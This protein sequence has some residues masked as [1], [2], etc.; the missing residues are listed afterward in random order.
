MRKIK[1]AMIVMWGIVVAVMLAIVLLFVSIV[2]GWTGYVPDTRELQNPDYLYASQLFTADGEEMGTWSYKEN[3]VR[4]EFKDIPQSLI[5]ALVATEDVRFYEHSGID[6]KSLLRVGVKSILLQQESSGGGSTITQQLAKML[7]TKPESGMLA[8]IR[9]KPNEWVIAAKLEKEYTKNE[10][11]TLY[12]NKYDFG[13]NAVGLASAAH[14]YFGKHPSEL[15]IEESATLVGMCKNSSLYNP[16]RRNELTKQ[17]RNVVLSQMAKAGY[18]TAA[19]RDSLSSI[20]LLT[21]YHPTD[22]NEGIAPYFREYLR[23]YMT[24]KKPERKNYRGWQKQQFYD[25]SIR[26]ATDSLYGWCNRNFKPNGE[27]YNITKDGLK[28]YTTIDSRMQSYL[29]EAVQEH[30]A[31]KLQTDF[32]KAK[33]G[34]RTAPFS[35]SLKEDEVAAIMTRNMK[36]TD[37]YKRMKKN[38]SSQQE[39]EE[40]FNTKIP[41]KVFTYQGMKDTVM[42]PMDSIKYYKHFLRTGAMSMDPLSGEIKA[43]VG[44]TNYH[45]FKYD[46]VNSGRRQVGSTIKPFLYSLAMERGFSPCDEVRN[47]EQT[48]V[49]DLGRIWKPRNSSRDKYGEMVTLRWGLAKS[50]NWISAYLMEQLSPYSLKKLVHEFGLTNQQIEATQSLCLGTCDAS[51]SEMV[52]G[53]TA[54]V[55]K[56]MRVAPLMVTRIEDSA[57]NILATF[58]AHRNEVISRESSYKMIDMMRGVINEGTGYRLR[59]TYKITADM[60]GKTGTT[61]NMSDGWFM[62]YTPSLVTGCWVGG[63]ERNIHFDKMSEGQGAA[64]ALPIYGLYM[65]KVYADESLPYSQEEKFDIP[66]DFDPCRSIFQT[67]GNEAADTSNEDVVTDDV[68]EE[69]EEVEEE[70]QE[71]FDDLFD[72]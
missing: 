10:I 60:C 1:I 50:N 13:N 15:L 41:M 7:H 64:M 20:P 14:V 29:E 28:I 55:G 12:L 25:D 45:Y 40:A 51:V 49:D 31:G 33:K 37:R 30:V 11:L 23:L 3:R 66:E 22:H 69:T 16:L 58:T 4:V 54:F 5:N 24:A 9:Q 38:G 42:T 71:G 61:Q 68:S 35:S 8:R 18:I 52:S 48:L 47:V 36:Q 57:G 56:G 2:N 72:W 17:R 65:Q 32:F 26:W 43:Y 44:G 6:A 63:E 53:Y 70:V 27:K 59:G 46:M 34:K 62:G 67:G 21:Y 19:E 39:I